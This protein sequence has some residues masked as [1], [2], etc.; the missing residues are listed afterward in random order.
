M[1]ASLFA[2]RGGRQLALRTRARAGPSPVALRSVALSPF[3]GL[4]GVHTQK[5]SPAVR[6]GVHSS[7]VNAHGDPHP[8]DVFQ[9]LDTFPR[10]HI[11]PSPDAASQMLAVLDPPAASLDSN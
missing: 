10:R 6:R 11:G 4:R 3:N 1:A 7:S 2:L 9:P 8:P 5:E